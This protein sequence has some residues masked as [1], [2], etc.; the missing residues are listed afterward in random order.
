[1]HNPLRIVPVNLADNAVI[2]ATSAAGSLV[3]D[4]LRSNYKPVLWRSV[5]LEETITIS[6]PRYEFINCVALLWNNLSVTSE[7]R[8]Q[9]FDSAGGTEVHD[10]GWLWA[11]APDSLE[12]FDWG[13]EGLGE[14]HHY[15]RTVSPAYTVVWL[16]DLGGEVVSVSLRDLDNPSGFIEVSRVLVGQWWAPETTADLGVQVVYD[17]A[18]QHSRTESGDLRTKSRYKQKTLS[19]SMSALSA[20]EGD[21]VLS[22][23][24]RSG[25]STPVF[26]SLYPEHGDPNLERA[27]QVYGKLQRAN[28]IA[29][30]GF[31]TRQARITIEEL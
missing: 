13:G 3:P 31:N 2:T 12:N 17:D 28:P 26:V 4:N 6:L 20:Q 23:L 30:P 27:Y 1:M 19:F 5:G 24:G 25:V 18:S 11:N 15:M 16:P 14:N 29:T 7:V 8:V 21:T 10:T 22:M 9:V